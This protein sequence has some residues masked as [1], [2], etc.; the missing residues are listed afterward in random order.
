M[1]P[2]PKPKLREPLFIPDGADCLLREPDVLRVLAV[3]PK[4]FQN[5]VKDGSFPKPVKITASNHWHA[6]TVRQWLASQ[7]PGGV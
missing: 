7:K 2:K 5:M 3:C 6:S 4:T 1:K